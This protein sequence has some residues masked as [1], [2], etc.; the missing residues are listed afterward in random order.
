MSVKIARA[1]VTPRVDWMSAGLGTK[2]D[3]KVASEMGLHHDMVRK[4]R[5]LMGIPPF[6][7]H[8]HPIRWEDTLIGKVLDRELAA[9]LGVPRGTV[10]EA[11]IRLGIPPFDTSRSPKGIDWDKVELGTRPDR[12]VASEMGVA[13]PIVCNARNR[14]GIAPF[15]PRKS[16][17]DWDK[18]P[19][20]EYHDTTLAEMLGVHQMT[21]TRHRSERG[22]PVFREWY[23]TTEKEAAESRAE[24]LIDL[25]WHEQGIPHVFQFPVEQYR[26]DWLIHGDTL[27]EYAGCVSRTFGAQYRARLDEKLAQYH[28]LGFKTLVIYPQDLPKYMPVGRP[29]TTGDIL[30]GGVNWSKQPLGKIPDKVL[31]LQLGVHQVTVTRWRNILG[32][33]SHT[34]D[35]SHIPLGTAT[36]AVFARQLGVS[37][38]TVRRA[39]A[40]RN[41]PSYR[42]SHAT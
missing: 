2:S 40:E 16:D 32:I 30:S 38:N 12:E 13:T 28:V 25:F 34:R 1:N 3:R 18:V 35:W 42:S 15:T 36:D 4:Q 24:A 33:P 9:Q 10:I 11:R 31:A 7:K 8:R 23:T 6:G 39:R 14:R 27:V 41:I 22:L 21:V 17:V 19:F 37:T 26:A 29:E 20:G 5:M